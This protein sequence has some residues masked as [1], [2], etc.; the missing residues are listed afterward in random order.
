[1]R[2]DIL[3]M[4]GTARNENAPRQRIIKLFNK[5]DRNTHACLY[6]AIV[7]EKKKRVWICFR[8]EKS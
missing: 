5:S 8:F 2:F 4:V 3:F 1:M 6:I 7:Q